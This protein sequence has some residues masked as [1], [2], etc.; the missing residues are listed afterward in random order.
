VHLVD[1]TIRIYHDAQ[2]PERPIIIII[3]IITFVLVYRP[4]VGSSVTAPQFVRVQG[5]GDIKGVYLVELFRQRRIGM[6][7]CFDI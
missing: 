6:E 3:I 4:W 5:T 1:F 2:S 7:D